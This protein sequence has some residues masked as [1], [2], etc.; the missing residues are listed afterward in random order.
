MYSNKTSRFYFSVEQFLPTILL[1]T[2][3]FFLPC[4][5]FQIH[6]IN[7]ACTAV[8]TRSAECARRNKICNFLLKHTV[9]K[10]EL[11]VDTKEKLG[12]HR[13]RTRIDKCENSKLF[14][15]DKTREF[16]R[17]IS[18]H[19]ACDAKSSLYYALQC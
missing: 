1:V 17:H 13:K 8:T 14:L 10:S 6:F 7:N 11:A 12:K 19:G 9:A 15:N 18:K 16:W 4:R 3:L 2:L 5:C